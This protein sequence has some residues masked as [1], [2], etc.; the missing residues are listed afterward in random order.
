MQNK[1]RDFE[2]KP[3]WQPIVVRV[4]ALGALVI[5]RL[6]WPLPTILEQPDRASFEVVHR[7][8]GLED[9]ARFQ[10]CKQGAIAVNIGD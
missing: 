4:Q 2:F 10:L 9:A 6:I 1:N 3:S 5:S 8:V 7:A